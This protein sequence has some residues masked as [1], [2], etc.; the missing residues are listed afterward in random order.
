MLTARLLV[1][2]LMAVL[3]AVVLSAGGLFNIILYFWI[4]VAAPK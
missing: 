2:V 1:C 3:C 4:G